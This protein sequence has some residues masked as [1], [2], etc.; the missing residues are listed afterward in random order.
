MPYLS[1][2]AATALFFAARLLLSSIDGDSA[3]R[4]AGLAADPGRDGTQHRAEIAPARSDDG[5]SPSVPGTEEELLELF[6]RAGSLRFGSEASAVH[7][8]LP[9]EVRVQRPR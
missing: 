7:D 4:A 9:I 3:T 8:F 6:R 1:P 5:P 2:A